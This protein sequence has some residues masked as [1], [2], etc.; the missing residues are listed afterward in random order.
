MEY[1]GRESRLHFG[2][3]AGESIYNAMLEAKQSIFVVSPY[4]SAGYIDF[5][6]QRAAEG[7]SVTVLTNDHAANN[8]N[9]IYRKILNQHCDVND[10]RRKIRRWGMSLSCLS[11]LSTL[12]LLAI[13]HYSSQRFFETTQLIILLALAVTA[14]IIFEKIRTCFYRYS[15]LFDF[16][17]FPLKTDDEHIAQGFVHAKIY[18][19]DGQNIFVGSANLT[20]SSFRHNIEVVATF[21]NSALCD[22]IHNEVVA[23]LRTANAIN[24]EAMGPTL[25]LE[26][27]N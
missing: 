15:K 17:V 5:L 10:R 20:W 22:A 8:M 13:Q 4:L 21:S 16:F 12:A 6:V 24:L 2:T 9:D 23:L 11:L 14:L 19:I 25:Y 26:P 18:I 27:A 3:N 1:F 7:I